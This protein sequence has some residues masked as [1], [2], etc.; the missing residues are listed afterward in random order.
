MEYFTESAVSHREVLHKIKEKYGDRARILTQRNVRMGGFMGMFSREGIEVSGY[1]ARETPRP[2]KILDDEEEKRKILHTIKDSSKDKDDTGEQTLKEVLERLSD[3]QGRLGTQAEDARDETHPA[4]REIE[5]LLEDNE[6]SASY[7][8]E[9]CDRLRR[10]LSLEELDQQELVESRVFS[11]IGD[12]IRIY[13]AKKTPKIMILIGPTGVGKTT[14]IAKLAAIY[15][16]GHKGGRPIDVR[17]I[18][19]DNYRIGAKQQIDTYG[20]IMN[21]PVSGVESY[22]DFKKQL[23]MYDGTD[24]ILVDTIGKSPR[25]YMKLAEMRK[26]LDAC[27]TGSEVFLTL[28]ST[29]KVSD[30]R[31]LFKTFGPFGYEALILTKLDETLRIG[32]VLS[33]LTEQDKPVAFLTDGQTVPQDIHEAS[34]SRLM[35]NLNGFK[36]AKNNMRPSDGRGPGA[37]KSAEYVKNGVWE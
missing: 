8:R 3:I 29:T 32:N 9:I 2:R 34:V 11:W 31:E 35:M 22:D 1:I 33:V 23:A 13:E 26:L 12:K 37:A 28:S 20:S 30:I 4:I 21:I 36:T 18:T 27:G 6:F 19:I 7:I 5:N 24:L 14:T 16:L 15:G 25:D 10:E 17:M